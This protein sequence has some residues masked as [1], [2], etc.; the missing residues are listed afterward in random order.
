M[1]G[2]VSR[3][4]PRLGETSQDS[5]LDSF[6][7]FELRSEMKDRVWFRQCRLQRGW[8]LADGNG[9]PKR[10]YTLR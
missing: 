6:R 2:E 1:S 5:S 10:Q 7:S 9:L 8:G 4:L 3:F